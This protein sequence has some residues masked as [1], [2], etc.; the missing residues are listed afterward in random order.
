[1]NNDKLQEI[2]EK[3]PAR[4]EV[5]IKPEYIVDLL[6]SEVR[7]VNKVNDN[8]IKSIVC[9][10]GGLRN[11]KSFYA[12]NGRSWDLIGFPYDSVEEVKELI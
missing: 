8:E 3:S 4:F 2:L 12:K 5:F 1:M 6:L 11:E 7:L 9:Y 10:Y